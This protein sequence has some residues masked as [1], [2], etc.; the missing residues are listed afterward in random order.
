MK[1]INHLLLLLLA[2][3][4]ILTLTGCVGVSLQDEGLVIGESYRLESGKTLNTDM[5]VLGGNA[6]IEQGAAVNGDLA[7]IGGNVTIDGTIS[8]DVSVLG[9]SVQLKDHAVVHGGLN[10]LGGTVNR[11]PGAV[12][13]GASAPD[14]PFR[15]T[16]MR[17]PP[18]RISF[19][20]ITGPLMAFFQAL[21]LAA[22]A[23]L[24]QLFA[25]PQMQR[26]GQT[27][28]AQPVAAGGVGMLTM[29]IAPALLV[30]MAVTIILLPLSLLGF[31]VLGLAAL[32]GWLSLG[33][34]VGRQLAAWLK[35]P[36][37]DPINAGAGTL[38]L[39]LLSS[40]LNLIPC[41]GWLATALIWFVALGTA[42]LTR[43]GMQTYPAPYHAPAP[44][45]AGPYAPAPAPA[46]TPRPAETASPEIET[47]G[48]GSEER[49]E[50]TAGS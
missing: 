19:D 27:A 44:R 32:Y 31:L 30:I 42:I 39:S 38:A 10:A 26:T 29:I 20:P 48:T 23:I 13:E 4:F 49:S 47:G 1:H 5:T 14:F 7:V 9:G 12:V 45:P 3:L 50:D 17:T 34:M 18:F 40:M 46:E 21:A 22:L 2:G 33:L 16:T 11:D 35:Q 8:G 24:V 37:T 36:W 28:V 15:I 43:F 41:L 25:A 6:E